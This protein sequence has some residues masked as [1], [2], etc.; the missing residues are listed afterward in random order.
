M[1]NVLGRTKVVI[2]GIPVERLSAGEW[3]E[4]LLSDWRAIGSGHGRPK[5]VTTANGQ[6]VSLFATDP[7]YRKA[8]LAADHVAADGMSV[9]K[10]SRWRGREAIPERV[11]T[12]D[13]FHD[14]ARAASE[15]GL[16]FYMIGATEEA[17][18]RAVARVRE[19][20]PKLQVVGRRNGYF[21]DEEIPAIAEQ[22]AASGADVLWLAVGNPRQVVV[23]HRF[24]TLLPRVTWVRTCGGLFDFLAGERARAPLFLQKAGLEW[25]WRAA[26]EPRR[27]LWRYLTTNV[28][29][30]YLMAFRSGR[31]T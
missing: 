22:V 16:K 15:H 9:V 29:S 20:Y 26:L 2:G 18:E 3:C 23:A 25:A 8:V 19:M 28:H 11:S 17:N 31:A 24:K 12:T 27:L 21:K 4:Q 13:W 14:A 7:V 1:T 10:A 30:T 5:V 6:V